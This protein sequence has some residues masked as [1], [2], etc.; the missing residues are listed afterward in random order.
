MGHA[1]GDMA[2]VYRERISDE[3]LRAAT[4]H[5]RSWL[6]L[7]KKT[8]RRRPTKKK[9][10]AAKLVLKNN[11]SVCMIRDYPPKDGEV[12]HGRSKAEP[13]TSVFLPR[14]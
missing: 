5:V 1:R 2:S 12:D 14:M 3:R 4:E 10:S 7:D 11:L 6:K 8:A 13:N 9:T